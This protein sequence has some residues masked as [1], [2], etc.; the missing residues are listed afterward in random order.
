[1]RHASFRAPA[2]AVEGP[3]GRPP[4]SASDGADKR[5]LWRL[6]ASPG[7]ATEHWQGRVAR[8]AVEELS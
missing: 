8:C 2:P 3:V 4:T 1:M 6:M 7:H 5:T